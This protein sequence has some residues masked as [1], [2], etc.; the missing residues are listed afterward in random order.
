M[1]HLRSIGRKRSSAD[2]NGFPFHVPAVRTL[3][4]LALSPAVTLFVGENGSGK[5][6][7]L[8]A[9]AAQAGLPTVGAAESGA[10]ETLA[11]QRRLA[12]VLQ[13]TWAKRTHKGF[14]LRAE[15]FFGFQKRL[16]QQQRELRA[17][18][19]EVDATYEGRSGLAK[20]L[21]KG[22]AAA[23]LADIAR[24]YG[25]DPDARSHGEAFLDLFRSRFV[26]G[27]L[28]L[29]DEPEAALSPQSQLGLLAM[30][31]DMV[32]Q[33]A[34]FVIATHSPMLLAYPKA[35][36]Y[37][38]DHAPVA[39]VAYDDLDHV[40]LTRDFLSEPERFLRQSE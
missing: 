18:L 19:D 40:R 24:R 32:K 31:L 1:P 26:P 34:Q 28:Y 8:E 25:E 11:A 2:Q 36:I 12:R 6:T 13:L 7:V 39:A 17:R 20:A 4:T 38:F 30:L 5:S 37:S 22:P 27:G 3:P 14:F 21:A 16:I 10:D 15:D 9:I 33:N 29:L 23:S 35:V